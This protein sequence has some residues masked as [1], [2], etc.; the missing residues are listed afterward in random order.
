MCIRD[1][2]RPV[3]L[4]KNEWNLNQLKEDHPEMELNSV[5]PVVSGVDPVS[6]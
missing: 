5:A 3:L 1:R 2:L 6:L 4:F